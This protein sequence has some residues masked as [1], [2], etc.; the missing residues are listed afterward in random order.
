[1]PCWF[2]QWQSYETQIASKTRLGWIISGRSNTNSSKMES[3]F[4][5]VQ[6]HVCDD[7]SK[8][9]KSSTLTEQVKCIVEKYAVCHDSI[10]QVDSATSTDEI[11]GTV[12][13]AVGHV[14][15]D[16]IE[17]VESALLIEQVTS[18]KEDVICVS[19]NNCKGG[20]S[21]SKQTAVKK[22]DE[23][24]FDNQSS[25]VNEATV[26]PRNIVDK[27][28]I[29]KVNFHRSKKWTNVWFEKGSSHNLTKCLEVIKNSESRNVSYESLQIDTVKGNGLEPEL[30][31][32]FHMIIANQLYVHSNHL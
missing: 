10:G 18:T 15:D 4:Y 19:G 6:L 3:C 29:V 31:T 9:I 32:L 27:L 24:Y 23:S 5:S 2:P 12:E 21:E 13:Y 11:K 26:E 17:Q 22:W 20:T 16:I 25:I 7:S 8:R 30:D 14:C 1:M 28:F